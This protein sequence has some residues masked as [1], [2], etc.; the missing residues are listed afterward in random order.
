[1]KCGTTQSAKGL[2]QKG[3]IT[4]PLEE[5]RKQLLSR[6]TEDCSEACRRQ[7]LT[8]LMCILLRR[9]SKSTSPANC[10]Q[11]GVAPLPAISR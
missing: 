3:Q 6:L 8:Q 7:S 4:A 10:G 11:V 2:R 9:N 5:R 1:M